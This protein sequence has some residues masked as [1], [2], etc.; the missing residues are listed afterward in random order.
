M[1]T[2]LIGTGQIAREH[3]AA[4]QTIRGVEL[5]GVCDRSSAVAELTAGQFGI[6]AW[7][8]RMDRLLLEA[9]PEVVH[10]TTPPDSHHEIASAALASG[11]HVL[12]E[13]PAATNLLE[14]LDLGERSR[15]AGRQ[16]VEHYN[17]LYNTPV[18]SLTQMLDRGDLGEVAHVEMTICVDLCGPGSPFVD[19]HQPHP[20]LSL[21]GGAI[22]D[23]LPHMASLVTRFLGPHRNAHAH[24]SRR[25]GSPLPQDELRALVECER[26]TA[27]LNFSTL[28]GPTRFVFRVL[29][30]ELQAEADLL[31]PVLIVH[32]RRA[33]HAALVPFLNGV[34]VARNSWRGAREGLWRRLAGRPTGYEG[35]RGFIEDSHLGFAGIGP[36]PVDWPLIE[37]THRLIA[38]LVEG[39]PGR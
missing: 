4:L 17:Y 9:R 38:A 35:I 2:A 34:D 27:A 28:S 1:R 8:D 13:K 12:V 10:I 19:P 31:E 26:G 29:A 6:P 15:R 5:V 30:R 7:Y 18:R 22:A 21:P 3:L 36:P 32:R 14:V 37:G 20:A 33:C 11:A 24:W 39:L 23:F 16:L 25:A